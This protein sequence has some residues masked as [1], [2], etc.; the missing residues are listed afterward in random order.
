MRK[1]DKKLNLQ[2]ANLLAEQRYLKNKGFI[3]ENDIELEEDWKSNVAAGL[4][5]VGSFGAQSA[6]GQT[7]QNNNN[8]TTQQSVQQR[9]NDGKTA[10]P[11]NTQKASA[12]LQTKLANTFR[13]G[14]SKVNPNDSEVQGFI[15]QINA[16]AQ[17]NPGAIIKVDIVG[18][19]SQV[20]NQQNLPQGAIANARAKS[21]QDVIQQSVQANL[22][23]TVK[24]TRG[25]DKWVAGANK[26]DQKYA[27]DQFVT[28]NV[29]ALQTS[30]SL[31][32]MEKRKGSTNTLSSDVTG[33][34]NNSIQP[35]NIPDRMVLTDASGS[36]LAD[37]GFF[38][39]GSHKYGETVKLI[40]RYVA[41]L[42]KLYQNNDPSVQ[43]L[44]KGSIVRVNSYDELV[45][46]LFADGVNVKDFMKYENDFGKP[47]QELA[48]MVKNGGEVVLYQVDP[49]NVKTINYNL[50]GKTGK[51]DV[52]SP[53]KQT[54]FKV[55]SNQCQ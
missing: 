32:K 53:L 41:E 24:T 55:S 16:F 36:V 34:I 2:K 7:Q 42:T 10:D 21:V 39:D 5:T 12:R 18:S 44:P 13:S 27:K 45:K 17:R 22:Q 8:Q 48:Q 29:Q 52:Y 4:A 19:E 26:D 50:T 43:N 15:Q 9:G 35:G 25:A 47:L 40:P 37:T 3:V 11:F 31:T 33:V 23:F 30:C 1:I 28:V 49:S 54:D 51:I 38:A 14:E 46:I 6:Q 20:P